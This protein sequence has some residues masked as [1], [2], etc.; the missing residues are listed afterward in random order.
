MTKTLALV[1]AVAVLMTGCSKLDQAKRAYRKG[2]YRTAEELLYKH[3]KI[4]AND[5]EAQNYLVLVQSGIITDTAAG[6]VKKG[7][8]ATAIPMLDR[9]IGLNDKNEDAKILLNT[10]V[11]SLSETILKTLV[12]AGR[13]AEVT[14]SMALIAEYRPDDPALASAAAR[15]VVETEKGTPNWKTV[16]AV[17]R[18]LSK[19]PDDPFLKDKAAQLDAASKPFADAY[20]R[21][22]SAFLNK[23]FDVWKALSHP[24]YLRECE[25]DVARLKERSDPNVK[26]VEDYFEAI[27]G[28]AERYGAPAGS[29]VVCVEPLS[30]NRGFVHYSFPRL[31]KILKREFERI[32][33]GLKAD[34][35]QDSEIRKEDLK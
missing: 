33:G 18:G 13:W 10:C 6:L 7:D 15:A 32:G 3:I 23:D 4:N 27:C 5:T 31:P 21:F 26:S 19:S 11:T 9:A 24:R 30:P 16:L 35:E 22:E 1:L 12:P 28:D 14:S 29:E 2:D 8:I 34:R 25:A 17:R 20:V